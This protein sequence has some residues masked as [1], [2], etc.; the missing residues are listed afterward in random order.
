MS[1]ISS[2]AILGINAEPIIVETDVSQGMGCFNVV[3]LPDTA[4]K[5]ARERIRSAIRNSGFEFPRHRVTVNLAPADIKK[6]GPAFDLPVALSLLQA[7]GEIRAESSFKTITV[8]ELSLDGAVRPINGVLTAALMASRQGYERLIVPFENAAEASAVQNLSVFGVRSLRDAVEHLNGTK[9]LEAALLD[10]ITSNERSFSSDFKDVKGQMHAKR[11]LEIAAAGGHNVLL[12]GPPGTGK[13]LLARAM[14]SILPPLTREESLD[15][16]SIA[17]VAGVLPRGSGLV[18]IRP[19]RSPHHSCSAVSLVGGGAW[20]RPGEVS[21]AHRG[22]LFL[23]ELPEFSRHVLEHLRQPL[24]DGEV[25][26]SRAAA[27]LRFPSRF[28]LVA[29]MNPCPCGFASDPKRACTCSARMISAYRK[30]MSGPLLDRIDLVIEVP[31]L[32]T[33]TLVSTA[34]AEPSADIRAR[35]ESARGIQAER[36]AGTALVTNSEIPSSRMR[37]WC[38][39][40][41]DGN[42]LLERALDAQSLSPRGYGRVLKVARTIADLA[43]SASIR[44][45]HVAEALGYRLAEQ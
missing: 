1:Y 13:T 45:E 17:S 44:E 10:D 31:N 5:E 35:V 34:T 41:D 28:L 12:K 24:E 37:D 23:D 9:L 29:A 26:V 7:R 19:F 22:V 15:V 20:P 6:Q 8:G 38:V 14:P 25:T 42:R 33:A 32:D 30:R 11:G 39:A 40:D 4:V 18:T 16:T 43:G 3:G 36:F 2:A 27:T 21:L